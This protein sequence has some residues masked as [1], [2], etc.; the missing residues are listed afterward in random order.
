MINI[1]REKI[2]LQKVESPEKSEGF[3]LPTSSEEET[4][5][6][7]ITHMNKYSNIQIYGYILHCK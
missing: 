7:K 1:K 5:L 6:L 2:L 4:G 3:I